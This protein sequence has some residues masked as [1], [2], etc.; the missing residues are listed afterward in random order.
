MRYLL[1]STVLIDYSHDHPWGR[2]IMERLFAESSELY[3]CAVVACET[4]SGGSP[5]QREAIRSALGALEY[6]AVN[7][8]GAAWA[9]DRRRERIEAGHR[10]PSLGDALIAGVAWTLDATIVTRNARDFEAFGIPVL[11]YGP[12]LS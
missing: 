5:E 7:P 3:T 9:G 6:V 2:E 4:L 1:D 12:Q 8:E 10:K 11:G